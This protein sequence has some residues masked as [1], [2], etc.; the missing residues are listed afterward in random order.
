MTLTLRRAADRG[1]VH[2]GWLDSRHTFSFGGYR[3]P[4]WMGFGT[5]R[6]LNEDRVAPGTGF[7]THGHTDMEIVSWVLDGRLEH[8]DSMGQGSVLV[9]GDVQL[10]SAGAGVTH[11]EFNASAT[12]PL[13]FLQMW[14]LPRARGTAPRYEQRHVPP[15]AR[16]GRLLTLASPDGADGTLT[17]GQDARLLTALLAPGETLRHALAGARAWLQVASGRVALDGVALEAGDGAG[18]TDQQA[19][20]IEGIAP[21]EIVLFDLA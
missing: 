8:R 7:G 20:A 15:E 21:A 16:R 17:L 3:D 18:V 11:S 19:L 12:E 9:P 13:H 4:D 2:H 6:V 14:V 10:L 5:L 1:H